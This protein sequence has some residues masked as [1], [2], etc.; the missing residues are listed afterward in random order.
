MLLPC[1]FLQGATYPDVTV[2]CGQS[3]GDSN[4]STHMTNPKLVVEVL[5]P[6]TAEHDRGDKLEHY[7]QITSLEAVVLIDHETSR[8]ELW[9]RE[10]NR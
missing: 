1:A 7:R 6:A 5:S 3:E 4:S 10:P 9:T 8:I 2:I